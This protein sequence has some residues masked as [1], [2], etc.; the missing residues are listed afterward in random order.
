MANRF[1]DL[2]VVEYSLSQRAFHISTVREMLETNFRM[3]VQHQ[4][5]NDYLVVGVAE[6]R[7]EADEISNL[8]REYLEK[9]EWPDEISGE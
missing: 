5:S 2:W 4:E 8:F 6:T 7:Q 1:M 9:G 3:I